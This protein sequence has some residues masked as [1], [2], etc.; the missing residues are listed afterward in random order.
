MAK[1]KRHEIELTPKLLKRLFEYV[2]MPSVGA[3]EL[4]SIVSNLSMLTKSFDPVTV[5]EF[6]LI[7]TKPTAV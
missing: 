5:E 4:D 2:R 3:E 6:D 1:L 7:V